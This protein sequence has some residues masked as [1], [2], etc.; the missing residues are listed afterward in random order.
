VLKD[1]IN[2]EDEDE[3]N[4]ETKE[5]KTEDDDVFKSIAKIYSYNHWTMRNQSFEF[6]EYFLDG[7]TNG[8]R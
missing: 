2:D 7:I 1:N 3:N 8:G 4:L 5:S 6:D